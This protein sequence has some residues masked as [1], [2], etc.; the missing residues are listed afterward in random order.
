MFQVLLPAEFHEQHRR[1]V[2]EFIQ[3]GHEF[4][5][6]KWQQVIVAFDLL[7][8]A[9]VLTDRGLLPFPV[10]Y[11]QYVEEPYADA[12]IEQLYLADQVAST[13]VSRWATVAR[14]IESYIP[15]TSWP[16]SA[17]YSGYPLD[18]GLLLVEEQWIN[19][20]LIRFLSKRLIRPLSNT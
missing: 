5:R 14:A 4:G 3:Y 7:K 18:R 9:A 6:G 15:G 11:R 2:L 1:I 8:N 13:S 19:P 17:R 10:I 12:F 16:V 20:S